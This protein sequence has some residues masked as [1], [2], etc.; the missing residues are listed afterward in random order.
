MDLSLKYTFL[1]VDDHEAALAFYRDALGFE[2]RQ[3][4]SMEGARWLTVG[5]PSQPALGIVLQTAGVARPADDAQAL[6]EL[7]A[8]GSLSG[9][10]LE[11]D[12]VDDTFE[13]VRATGAEVLQEPMDQPYGT[14]DCAFRDPAGNQVRI[15]QRAKG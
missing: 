12:S 2:V 13:S 5:P 8:K 9:L 1:E 10:V 7:L 4:V 3:D 14:R 15:N 11:T 6:R